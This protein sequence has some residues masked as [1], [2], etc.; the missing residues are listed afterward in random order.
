MAF[1]C[2][3]EVKVVP[4]A[5]RNAVVGW[6]GGAL[7]IKVR[8]PALEERANDELRAFLAG[9]LDVPRR[10]VRLAAGEKSRKKSW[11]FKAFRSLTFSGAG[12]RIDSPRRCRNRGRLTGGLGRFAAHRVEKLLR[13][14][15]SSWPGGV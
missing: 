4:N 6:L 1:S 3:F 8:A 2:R 15:D 5:Q 14:K 12:A 7:K 13:R 10:A 11:R 9:Q